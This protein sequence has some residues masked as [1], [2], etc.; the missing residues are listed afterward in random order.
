MDMSVGDLPADRI[1][2]LEQDRCPNMK[3]HVRL[4]DHIGTQ[5]T[6]ISGDNYF[7]I[8][9]RERVL[10]CVGEIDQF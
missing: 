2:K 1:P 3:S 6:R 5:Q 4:L 9:D 10:I 8:T 7:F